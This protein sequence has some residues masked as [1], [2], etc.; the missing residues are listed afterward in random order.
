M[1]NFGKYTSSIL[2]ECTF[3]WSLGSVSTVLKALAKRKGDLLNLEERTDQN[4]PSSVC[5]L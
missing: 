5:I 1:F 2:E 4:L 3:L